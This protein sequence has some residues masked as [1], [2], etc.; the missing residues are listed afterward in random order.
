ML[1]LGS[2][3]L[4]QLLAS[5]AGHRGQRIDC[6]VGHDAQFV[7]RRDKNLDTKWAV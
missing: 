5:H 4:Q 6:G 1:R 3:L 2:S 7:D